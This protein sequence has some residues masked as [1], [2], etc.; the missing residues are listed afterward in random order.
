[1]PAAE[2]MSSGLPVVASRVGGLPEVVQHGETGLLVPPRDSSALAS[3]LIRLLE[4]EGLRRSMGQ[5]GRERVLRTFTWDA[6][7]E[8][9][10][11]RSQELTASET[12][13]QR[14]PRGASSAICAAKPLQ[15]E[16]A[17]G[18]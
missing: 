15:E 12:N 5:A 17:E 18:R 14:G 6:I 7:A 11:M 13:Q 9:F 16:V 3:A 10:V 4:D 2:A 1:M 8:A